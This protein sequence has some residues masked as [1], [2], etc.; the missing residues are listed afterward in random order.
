MTGVP[1]D[2]RPI[3]VHLVGSIPLADSESV[4]RA[5]GATLARHLRR[6]PDGETGKRVR[7]SSWTAPSY[8][9]TRG[10]ELVDPPPGSYTPWRQSRLVIDP[11]ELVL[12]RLG[13]ADAAI[14]SYATFAEL[15]RA[16]ALPEQV[17]FQVCLPSPVAPMSV[18]IEEG[19]RAAV[20]PAHIRQ[21]H[22]EIDEILAAVPHDE[23]AIQWD[24]CQDVGIWE[25]FY[26][27]YF[28]D[29]E[30]GVIERLRGCADKIP[31]DVQVGFHLCYGDYQHRHFM[32]PSDLGALTEIS[33][34]LTEATER[35]IDWIHMPVPIDRGDEAYYAPLR[36]LALAPETELY[37]GLIHFDD[38]VQGAERRITAAR[39]AVQQFGVGT[40]CGFG[41]RD[42]ATIGQLLELH[43]AIAAPIA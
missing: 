13:F 11:D 12:E 14:E 42:P 21:L 7:W 24:V 6:A 15:R 32:N 1:G 41:R 37:L 18:L 3:G 35:T 30:A 19:S 27:A 40:E 31:A 22:S 28:T 38:G 4:L 29:R 36:E 43:A 23:L 17:R 5:V 26:P 34:R 25:G 10:L 33:N 39:S 9:R 8:E 2:P 20:E 16:G